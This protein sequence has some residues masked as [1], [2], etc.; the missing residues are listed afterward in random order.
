MNIA[1]FL[2]FS[3]AA[4]PP[5]ARLVREPEP[6]MVL[7]QA[8]VDAPAKPVPPKPEPKPEPKIEKPV[9]KVEVKATPEAVALAEKVQRFYEKTNDFTADF[10][11]SFKNT[12]LGRTQ[13]SSGTVQVKKPGLMR[14]DYAKPHPKQF[15]LDGKDLWLYEPDDKSV[16][17]KRGFSSDS[18][19]AA[20]TFLFGKGRLV[21]E[22]DVA[23]VERPEYGPVVL[24]L[25]PKKSQPGFA[26]LFFAVDD[27]TGQVKTSIVIDAQGNENRITFANMKTNSGLDA[28]RFQF[29]PP[30]GAAV[31]EWK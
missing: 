25:V 22:F 20:V 5:F 17:V 2:G 24:S 6:V 29:A 12:M 9:P 21:D 23:R 31:Q 26:K 7:A 15:V 3:V 30:K 16:M 1:I 10:E 13:K 18:L 27:A 4:L 8:P 14:W 19:S 11:Q 28:A